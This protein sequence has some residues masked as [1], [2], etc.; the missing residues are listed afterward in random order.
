MNKNITIS[1]F[2]FIA[3][4]EGISFL[5]LL[6]IAMPLKYFANF[7]QAVKVGGMIHGV[8]F[9]AFVILSWEVM[10]K[11]E[12]KYSWFFSAF[13]LSIVPFGTFYLD[14]QLKKERN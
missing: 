4:A 5:F 7:P 8:L 14:K 3:L 2:R 1:I 6:F 9:V 13:L 11:L 12:K 10:N